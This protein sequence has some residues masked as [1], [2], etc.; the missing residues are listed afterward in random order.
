M[1]T[2]Y[3]TANKFSLPVALSVVAGPQFRGIWLPPIRNRTKPGNWPAI[4][5][6][7]LRDHIL[8]DDDLMW[9]CLEE[10]G[11]AAIEK[12]DEPC[13]RGSRAS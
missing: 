3:D 10:T 4:P 13:P 2:K 7:H 1:S 5:L 11:R 12:G 6:E 8:G 9:Y